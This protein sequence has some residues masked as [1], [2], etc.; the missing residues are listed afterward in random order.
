MELQST[1]NDII[2]EYEYVL[3]KIGIKY[4]CLIKRL[5]YN[6]EQFI[7]IETKLW[8]ITILFKSKQDKQL[9]DIENR[10]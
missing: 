2:N 6:D 4:F 10:N 7:N 9:F 5:Y 8:K 3:I 1:M